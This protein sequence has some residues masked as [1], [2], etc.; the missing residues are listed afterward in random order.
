[1]HLNNTSAHYGVSSMTLH[2]L[3]FGLIVLAYASIELKDA[4]DKE[5]EV[6]FWIKN[7][8]HAIGLLI[9]GLVGV[10]LGLKW[11]QLTPL[12]TPEPSVRQVIAARWGHI[13]LYVFMF[14]TPL[15]GWLM[16]SAKAKTI[17]FFGL[18]VPSLFTPDPVWAERFEDLHEVL[19][20]IGYALIALH[21]A[22]AL[23]NHYVLKDNT[24]IRMW[25]TRKKE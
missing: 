19:G 4:F 14:F 12:I 22:A 6:R 3:M 13:A 2:W 9:L 21:V 8:H 7:L 1:M 16:V 15:A 24:L 10:R 11:I 20:Q 17:W 25:P 18:N 5:S 23:F